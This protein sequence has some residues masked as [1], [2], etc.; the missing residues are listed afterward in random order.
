M[1][2][3]LVAWLLVAVTLVGILL[4]VAFWT[5]CA[6]PAGLR[7]RYGSSSAGGPAERGWRTAGHPQGPFYWCRPR[8]YRLISD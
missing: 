7:A 2:T 5:E 3:V 4:T 6:S 1:K 8:V